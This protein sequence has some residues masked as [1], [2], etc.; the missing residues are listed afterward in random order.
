LLNFVP[1]ISSGEIS[2]YSV[3]RRQRWTQN[4]VCMEH[5]SSTCHSDSSHRWVQVPR[6][7]A[8]PFRFC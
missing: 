2:E 4:R 8:S 1:V 6:Q 5:V 7:G 3:A